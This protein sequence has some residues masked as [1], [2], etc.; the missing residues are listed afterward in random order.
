MGAELK[1]CLEEAGV[2]TAVGD[3]GGFALNLKSNNDEAL[4]VVL[5]CHSARTTGARKAKG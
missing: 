3:S 5:V 4:E 1:R 2:S